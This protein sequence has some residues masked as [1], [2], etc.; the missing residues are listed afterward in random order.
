[1]WWKS[2]EIKVQISKNTVLY[3]GPVLWGSFNISILCRRLHH[4]P[5]APTFPSFHPTVIYSSRIS[6]LFPSWHLPCCLFSPCCRHL[7]PGHLNWPPPLNPPSVR[8]NS[9]CHWLE[10]SHSFT[11]L[12]VVL[13]L[14]LLASLS[15]GC[16]PHFI[17]TS[18]SVGTTSVFAHH[19]VCCTLH[20]ARKEFETYF[21]WD[22]VNISM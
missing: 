8:P 16:L 12:I 1:M 15:N 18:L 14:D 11:A 5:E 9:L 3:S 13:T 17:I 2:W 22:F 4:E 6:G 21:D 7:W 20:K 10:H 19:S